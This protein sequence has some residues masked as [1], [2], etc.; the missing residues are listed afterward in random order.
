M[1]RLVLENG[2]HVGIVP[3]QD[4][5]AKAQEQGLDLVE[6]APEADPPVCKVLDYGKF[7]YR[8]KK[9]LHQKHHKTELKEIR[10]G[11]ATDQHDLAYK[12]RR[13]EEF[14]REHNKVRVSM[15]LR[16]R[17]SAHRDQALEQLR[18]FCARFEELAKLE[19]PPT[20]EGAGRISAMLAPK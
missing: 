17:E 2:E 8:Q 16:G 14:L 9:R 18:T 1:V 4:A 10:I 11:L 15:R 6:I 5:L 13:V 20:I 7:K 19:R 12:A 3:L